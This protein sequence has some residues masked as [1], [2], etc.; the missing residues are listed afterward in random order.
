[1]KRFQFKLHPVATVRTLV[2][3]RE[4]ETLMKAVRECNALG[5]VL[6]ERKA[7][8]LRFSDEMRVQRASGIRGETQ[9]ALL[10]AYRAEIESEASADRALASAV[11]L[12]EASRVRW[13]GA[14][15]RTRQ[16]EDLRARART[17]H[18]ADAVCREQ[19]Q[20][21]DRLLRQPRLSPE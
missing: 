7:S 13:I 21:D 8:V 6:D 4:R 17:K 5:K 15:L 2:E 14:F 20:L 12:R 10:R 19:G 1:M 9:A 16:M 3:M 11:A 18:G